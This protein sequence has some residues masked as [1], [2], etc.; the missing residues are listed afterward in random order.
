MNTSSHSREIP[1][2]TSLSSLEPEVRV[3]HRADSLAKC[4]P[5]CPDCLSFASLGEGYC[6][7]PIL[8]MKDWSSERLGHLSK[9]TQLLRSKAGDS[10]PRLSAVHPDT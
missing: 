1:L 5:P 6:C 10:H 9:V 7:K 4:R 3:R 2:T 8:Q